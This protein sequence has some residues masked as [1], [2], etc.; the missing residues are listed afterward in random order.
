ML[1][2]LTERILRRVGDPLGTERQRHHVNRTVFTE[3]VREHLVKAST[4]SIC[5]RIARIFQFLLST[6]QDPR[7]QPQAD[8]EFVGDGVNRRPVRVH[9]RFEVEPLRGLRLRE[10]VHYPSSTRH[11]NDDRLEW[12]GH[13]VPTDVTQLKPHVSTTASVG[14]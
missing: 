3:Q 7:D 11:T 10:E 9:R 2:D 8:C 5:Y 12:Q 4:V 6:T 13:Q 1:V 14:Q